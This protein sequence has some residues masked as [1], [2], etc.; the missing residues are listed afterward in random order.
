MQSEANMI[1]K[2]NKCARPGIASLN[3]SP[4]QEYEG[5]MI[6]APLVCVFLFGVEIT[7]NSNSADEATNWTFHVREINNFTE[8]S[9]TV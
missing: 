6:I 9:F 4:Q 2:K 5:S 3:A 1:L 8:A 7:V